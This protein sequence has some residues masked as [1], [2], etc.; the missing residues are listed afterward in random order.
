MLSDSEY[1]DDHAV[2]FESSETLETF[3]LLLSNHFEKFEM[4]VHAG[5]CD[6]PSKPSKSE[7]LFVSAPPSSYA[8]PTLLRIE[9]YSLS[10]LAIT[11]P[12]LVMLLEW[13]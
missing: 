12:W 2:L 11:Q 10:A 7:V 4:E 9:I 3:W 5:L 8:K 1:A 13:I 6:Q